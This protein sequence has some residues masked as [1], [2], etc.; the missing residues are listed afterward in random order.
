MSPDDE[1][2]YEKQMK[3]PPVGYC[4]RKVENKW[5]NSKKRKKERNVCIRVKSSANV[6]LRGKLTQM[7]E[8]MKIW[9]SRMMIVTF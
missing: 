2:F 6:S 9:I 5:E 1:A 8:I 7:K 3:N 4:D